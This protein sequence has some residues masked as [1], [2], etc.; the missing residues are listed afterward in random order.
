MPVL[1]PLNAMRSFE[2]AARVGSFVLAGAELGV[3]AA[4]VSLQV[5]A[6]ETHLAKQLFQRQGNRLTLTA[7]GRA[8]YPRLEQA[9]RALRDVAADLSEGGARAPLVVSVAPSLA[10]FWLMPR[11]QGFADRARLHI[12]VE[13]DPV[14]MARDGVDLRL[15]YGAH[16]YPDHQV[17]SLFRDRILPVAIPGKYDTFPMV[18]GGSYIHTDWG[19]GYA[20]EPSWAAWAA[21]AGCDLPGMAAGLRVGQSGLALHAALAG[22]GAAL[23]PRSFALP[24]LADGRLVILSEISL[25]MVFDY[26]AIHG[27]GAAG[28]RILQQLLAHLTDPV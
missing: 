21:M 11:L 19:A 15:T 27:R 1:P 10:E 2:V 18:A 23:I 5:K 13:D 28:R 12:R 9:L 7:A 26:V 6:L 20:T 14:V 3:T 8:I 16:F 17:T 22:L 24:M 25:P 4:A